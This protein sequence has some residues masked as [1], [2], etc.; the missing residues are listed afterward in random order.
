MDAD[1][2]L[3]LTEREKQ[4]LAKQDF[5]Q[6]WSGFFVAAAG[7]LLLT[8]LALFAIGP[9]WWLR[10]GT[11]GRGPAWGDLFASAGF[12]PIAIKWV[13]IARIVDWLAGLPLWSLCVL[14]AFLIVWWT[15]GGEDSPEY[16]RA[17]QKRS[18]AEAGRSGDFLL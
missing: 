2:R 16:R 10:V 11:W 18:L 12:K 3:E 1:P 13:G 7:L 14:V 15:F 4:L 17:L 6:R 9:L 8:A 5:V